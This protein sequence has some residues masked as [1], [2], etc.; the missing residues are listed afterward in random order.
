DFAE[1]VGNIGRGLI[2]SEE[3]RAAVL[4]AIGLEIADLIPKE[5]L[6]GLGMALAKKGAGPSLLIVTDEA[7]IPWELARLPAIGT[8][9]GER[10]LGE[11]TRVGRWPI[12]ENFQ[13]PRDSLELGDFHVF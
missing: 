5:L 3:Q 13:A 8:T 11:V 1:T 9:S 10:Y 12:N 4:R 2:A 7:F 6:A